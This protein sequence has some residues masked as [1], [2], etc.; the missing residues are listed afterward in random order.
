MSR[1]LGVSASGESPCS[2][3]ANERIV[4]RVAR[5]SEL[6]SFDGVRARRENRRDEEAV[7]PLFETGRSAAT[8]AG[9]R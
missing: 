5:V 7:R 8:A 1:P 3:A 2:R 6:A 4:D 9:S